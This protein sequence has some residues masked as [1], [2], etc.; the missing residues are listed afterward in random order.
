MSK[1]GLYAFFKISLITSADTK[2]E[3]L[4]G[5]NQK[6]HAREMTSHPANTHKPAH[7]TKRKRVPTATESRQHASTNPT[8]LHS[9]NPKWLASISE[10]KSSEKSSTVVV[11]MDNFP[12]GHSTEASNMVNNHRRT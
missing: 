5:M 1:F 8:S 6:G 3:P 12:E 9:T 2:Y 11:P 7:S 10:H 4:H